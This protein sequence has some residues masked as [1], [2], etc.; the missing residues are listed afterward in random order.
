MEIIAHS[1]FIRTTPRKLRLVARKISGMETIQAMDILQ[2]LDKRAAQPLILVLKQAIGNATNNFGLD[3]DNLKIKTVGIGKGPTYKRWRF[4]GR[5]RVF[6]VQKKTSHIKMVLEGEKSKKPEAT[7]SET[8]TRKKSI[9]KPLAV[10][11]EL[12]QE[13]K[14]KKENKHG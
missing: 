13:E 8:K 3:K 1:K 9:K 4:V 7:E 11:K 14:N 12:N 10:S 2:N 5:G 6:Q